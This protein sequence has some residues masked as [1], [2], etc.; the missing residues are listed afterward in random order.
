MSDVSE[1]VR[2]LLLTLSTEEQQLLSR[3]LKV[4]HEVLYRTKPRVKE[5]YLK[6]TREVIK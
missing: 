5:E 4:E 3:F 2:Q 1:K 6:A